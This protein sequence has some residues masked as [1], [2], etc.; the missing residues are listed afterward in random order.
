[1]FGSCSDEEL[2]DVVRRA[3]SGRQIIDGFVNQLT[4]EARRREATGSGTPA[5]EIIR[6]GGKISQREAKTL[7]RRAGVSEVLPVVGDAVET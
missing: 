7:D 1:M 4:A 3:L 2:S 5:E 6:S